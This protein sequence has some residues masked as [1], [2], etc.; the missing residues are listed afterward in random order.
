MFVKIIQAVDGLKLGEIYEVDDEDAKVYIEA[1]QAEEVTEVAEVDIGTAIAEGVDS[2][3]KTAMV[4]GFKA[5]VAKNDPSGVVV[6]RDRVEGDPNCGWKHVGE[7]LGD[8]VRVATPN[9]AMPKRLD[10][11]VERL[12]VAGHMEEGDDSQGGFLVPTAF[13]PNLQIDR[14]METGLA[15]RCT[16]ILMQTNSVSI[17][18]INQTQHTTS[19]YGGLDVKR[20]GEAAAKGISKPTVGLCTLTLHKTTVATHVSDELLEDSLISIAPLLGSMM[21]EA[22]QFVLEDE[23]IN[24]TGAGQGLGIILAPATITVARAGAGA[25]ARADVL[26][27]Y[28]R[29]HPRHLGN[30]IWLANIDTMGQFQTMTQVVGTGGVATWIPPTGLDSSAPFGMLHGRPIFFIELAQTLGTAGDLI[31]A[32]LSQMFLG[33]K[34]GGIT[35]IESSI[36]LRF[37]F[38]ETT[39]KAELRSDNQPWWP[40][41]LTPRYSA[42]TISP[43]VI[44]G[45]AVTTTTT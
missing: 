30:S 9:T 34:T 22:L 19:V 11:Y 20:T 13:L 43:F 37:L 25:I 14:I 10:E 33:Q 40:A 38:D 44:L 12:K 35:G 1:G 7:F 31:F 29:L 45:D 17:P 39:F 15:A 41:P 4:E 28:R 21:P 18:Y 24:G 6:G 23:I 3:I 27:M 16:K 36:H 26:N 5:L 8:L 2:A 32:D 42:E